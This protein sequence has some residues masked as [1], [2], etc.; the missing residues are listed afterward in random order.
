[1][2]QYADCWLSRLLGVSLLS[3]VLYVLQQARCPALHLTAPAI[4]FVAMVF[5]LSTVDG[6]SQNRHARL[7]ACQSLSKSLDACNLHV[8]HTG[9]S[10]EQTFKPSLYW[11]K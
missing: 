9:L 4:M 10:A 8:H 7:A 6:S 2:P 11:L 1:M 3:T 5:A